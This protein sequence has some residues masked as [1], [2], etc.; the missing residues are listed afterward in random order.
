MQPQQLGYPSRI[1]IELGW[2]VALVKF[3]IEGGG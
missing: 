1:L 3:M 2:F